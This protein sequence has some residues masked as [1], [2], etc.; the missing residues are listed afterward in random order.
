MN[1]VLQNPALVYGLVCWG[2]AQVLK[3][4]T[5]SIREHRLSWRM[6]LSAGG[7]PSSHTAIISSI[8]VGIG[9]REGIDSPLFAL[10]AGIAGVVMYDAAGVRRAAGHQAAVLNQII[11]ELFQGHPIS[12]VRLRELLGHTPLQVLAGAILGV[13]VTLIGMNYIWSGS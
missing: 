11:D 13:A 12:E 10:A 5:S 3:V 7:M 6:L 4:A 8:T 2:M 1:Q 9:I